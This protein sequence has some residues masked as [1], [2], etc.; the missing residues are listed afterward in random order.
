MI[1]WLSKYGLP[2][3][4]FVRRK[5][6]PLGHELK[7]VCDALT[8]VMTWIELQ[9]GKDLDRRKKYVA[10][11]GATT[12]FVLRVCDAMEL[13]G[14]GKQ[15][16]MDSWFGSVKAV[17]LCLEREVYLHSLVK[18]NTKFYPLPRLKQLAAE[19]DIT[20]HAT[21]AV[22]LTA[23]VKL[24]GGTRTIL[25]VYHRGPAQSIL[26]LVTSCTT[27]LVGEVRDYDAHLKLAT[28]ERQIE[29]RKC[30]QPEAAAFYRKHFHAIDDINQQTND[31]HRLD[32]AWRTH[33]WPHRDFSKLVNIS[34]VSG[35]NAYFYWGEGVDVGISDRPSHF[36]SGLIRECFDN[37]WLKE[38]Q[39][40]RPTQATQETDFTSPTPTRTSSV[41]ADVNRVTT[42]VALTSPTA[43]PTSADA[44]GSA[45]QA[46][47][48]TDLT[49]SECYLEGIP[50]GCAQKCTVPECR[51]QCFS[52]CARC[53]VTGDQKRYAWLCG[54]KT[55][56]L[57]FVKHVQ[58]VK[59]EGKNFSPSRKRK[60]PLALKADK[61]HKA[62]KDAEA[63]AG[64][65]ITAARA[66]QQAAEA[67]SALCA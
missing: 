56:R 59:A 47:I 18:T 16:V 51:K 12:A 58:R 38:E 64:A 48:I 60:A 35:S 11:Y 63:T 66:A 54:A 61:V 39:Q 57:C 37:P 23:E 41:S 30:V 32:D 14:S 40:A 20:T 26:P 15:L 53:H 1:R 25:A 55:G 52:R 4:M 17:V 29:K 3:L 24:L 21:R 10:E 19:L 8:K 36:L 42:L 2:G 27:T 50:G 6:D 28:G 62:K 7:N 46:E 31:V 22:S 45:A 33:Y 5:P 49:V 13:T 34:Q 43:P 44:G 65:A 67:L 9:E